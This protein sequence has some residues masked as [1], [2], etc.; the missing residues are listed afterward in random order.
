MKFI[1]HKG[2]G[3]KKTAKDLH[4]KALLE[5]LDILEDDP[6]IL[7]KLKR[8]ESEIKHGKFATWKGAR[9]QAQHK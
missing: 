3:K 1:M 8:A 5:T 7:A 2:S 4:D 9:S 6:E